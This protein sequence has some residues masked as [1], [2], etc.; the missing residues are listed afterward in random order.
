M[1]KQLFIVACVI[2]V[3]ISGALLLLKKTPAP[4]SVPSVNP[5]SKSDTEVAVSPNL[6]EEMKKMPFRPTRLPRQP[7]VESPSLA[8]ESESKLSKAVQTII[9]GSNNKA[10]YN[11]YRVAMLQLTRKL[12]SDDISALMEF[13]NQKAADRSDMRAIEFNGVKNDVLDVL[14]R[15]D[16]LPKGIGLQLVEMYNDKSFDTMWRDYCVQFITNYYERRWIYAE[17]SQ[18][19]SKEADAKDVEREVIEAVYWDALKETDTT[20]AGTALLGLNSLSQQYHTIDRE[21]VSQ[22]AVD[23]LSNPEVGEPTRITAFSIAASLGNQKALPEARVVA[24]TGETVTL[25]MAAIAAIG[26]LGSVSDIELLTSLAHDG[27]ERIR[28]IAKSALEIARS[29]ISQQS[30]Q[31]MK[32]K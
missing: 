13:L 21:R 6:D 27:E 16:V 26:Q 18:T 12:S 30:V 7:I 20:I 11:D 22:A 8:P 14:L 28:R 15:Q 3:A 10:D 23:L 19:V 25:R 5:E 9:N 29:R 32:V 1:K 2:A 4:S 31:N 24:Q 17:S